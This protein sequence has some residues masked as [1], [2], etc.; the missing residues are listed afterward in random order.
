[1]SVL[2]SH[3][4]V[5]TLWLLIVHLDVC[6]RSSENYAVCKMIYCIGVVCLNLLLI[7]YDDEL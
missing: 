4:A 5:V 6:A 7:V 3:L 1:M 2:S